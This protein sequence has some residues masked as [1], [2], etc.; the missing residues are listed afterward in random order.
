MMRNE[1]LCLLEAHITDFGV[2]DIFHLALVMVLLKMDVSN[3]LCNV[4]TWPCESS[5]P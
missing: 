5:L 2:M 1:I 3:C 4:E